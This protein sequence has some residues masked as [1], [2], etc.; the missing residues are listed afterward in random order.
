MI[1]A[2]VFSAECDGCN[3]DAHVDVGHVSMEDLKLWREGKIA[4]DTLARKYAP[5]WHFGRVHLCPAC[6]AS[7]KQKHPDRELP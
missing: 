3:A 5:E 1:R 6:V 4:L 2:Q 7:N